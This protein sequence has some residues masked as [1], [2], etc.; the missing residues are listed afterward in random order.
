LGS[1]MACAKMLLRGSGLLAH[2]A[3]KTANAAEKAK[4]PEDI[5][6][7]PTA[8]ATADVAD[9]QLDLEAVVARFAGDDSRVSYALPASLSPEQRQLT[10]KLVGRHPQLECESYGFG[11]ERQLHLFKKRRGCNGV[12]TRVKNTFIDA[13]L[14]CGDGKA[15][16]CPVFRSLPSDWRSMVVAAL[17]A[18]VSDNCE[19]MLDVTHVCYTPSPCTSP[20]ANNLPNL[21]T[22]G[23]LHDRLEAVAANKIG[24][25][26]DDVL[27]CCT[28][29]PCNSPT[30]PVRPPAESHDPSGTEFMRS[31][32][33]A[34]LSDRSGEN[35]PLTGPLLP[36]P[37]SPCNVA[38]LAPGTEVEI[39]G[40]LRQPHF[41]GLSG[42]VQSWDPMLRRYDVL[43]DNPQRHV[44]LKR[45][46]LR[47]RT[48][49]PPPSAAPFAS[50]T[51]DLSRCLPDGFKASDGNVAAVN[52]AM[53]PTMSPDS[54]GWFP[55]QYCDPAMSP[56][57]WQ[58][59]VAEGAEENIMAPGIERFG[60]ALP[61]WEYIE[62]TTM[63][64][65]NEQ[66]LITFDAPESGPWL[67]SDAVW[68]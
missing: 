56:N 33:E 67:Q 27:V 36:P 12:R 58:T 40:L 28:P 24:T 26:Q 51:L 63:M 57:A 38:T 17:V 6:M 22:P 29:S 25:L 41:N 32:N 11:P 8:A 19:N 14:E 4:S 61:T 13:W 46:N 10:K 1:K 44:K 68:A 49:P 9:G 65:Y 48:A 37:V 16:G 53:S 30:S 39:D 55:W 2:G 50:T 31:Q 20:K 47:F 7:S 45:E 62:N 66:S 43:L 35:V 52:D 18:P 54:Q 60:G 15:E 3:E 23:Q 64:T 5:P 34:P 59:P 21:L 42:I